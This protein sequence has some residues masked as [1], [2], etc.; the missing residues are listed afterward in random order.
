MEPG[1]LFF[2][3]Y[4]FL[5]PHGLFFPV[6]VATSSRATIGGMAANNSAGSRSIKYG[7]MVDNVTS[8][9]GLMAD[10]TAVKFDMDTP[11]Q[12]VE[13][14]I[15]QTL[16]AL[17]RRE[18]AELEKRIPKVMRRVAGYNLDRLGE[19]GD[20]IPQILVGSEGTLSFFT[21]IELISLIYCTN[22]GERSGQQVA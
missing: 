11:T 19:Q 18:R 15:A 20:R 17:R 5:K 12:G 13:L 1:I 14:K 2:H 7:M 6:D 9:Q 16:A 4:Q 8:I 3:L 21:E 10:G 22:L